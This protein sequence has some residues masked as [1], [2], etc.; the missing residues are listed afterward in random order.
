MSV[1]SILFCIVIGSGCLYGYYNIGKDNNII[2][3]WPKTPGKIL[4]TDIIP[5]RSA[6]LQLK[7][8]YFVNGVRYESGNVYRNYN[9]GYGLGG[10]YNLDELEFLKNPEVKYNP[11]NPTD[12]CLLLWYDKLWLKIL[13]ILAGVV[14]SLFGW[15][16]LLA[17]MLN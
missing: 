17:K 9:R 10:S 1:V 5:G 2:K 14:L 7:Y 6:T 8:E 16:G 15:G 11:E 3:T 13:L 4:N 12:C